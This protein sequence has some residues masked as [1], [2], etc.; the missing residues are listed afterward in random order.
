[1]ITLLLLPN[2]CFTDDFEIVNKKL[3]VK[4]QLSN[5]LWKQ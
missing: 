4:H 5:F 1:M 3:E 2:M